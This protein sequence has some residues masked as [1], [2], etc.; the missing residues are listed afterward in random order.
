MPETFTPYDAVKN[1]LNHWWKITIF[2]IIFGL[3]GLG[4]TFIQP[5]KYQAEAIF[6]ATIDYRDINFDDL[7]EEDGDPL[8]FSQY[9]VD[10]ALSAVQRI[11]LDVR[12]RVIDYA[13]TLDPDLDAAE[14]RRRA[15]ERPLRRDPGVR[16]RVLPRGAGPVLRRDRAAGA[17]GLAHLMAD[18]GEAAR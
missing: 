13:K 1:L 17:L 4:F 8:T 14:D 6:S 10:L 15:A 11:L 7:Y 18:A 16:P 12:N 3:L 5:P 9:D 2:T